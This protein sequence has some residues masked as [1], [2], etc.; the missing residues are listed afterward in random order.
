MYA[1]IEG[2]ALGGKEEKEEEDYAVAYLEAG[3]EGGPHR[4]ANVSGQ[5]FSYLV[6]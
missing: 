4:A 6:Q 2:L 5:P 1:R 3:G